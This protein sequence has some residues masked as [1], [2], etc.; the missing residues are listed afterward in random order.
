MYSSEYY[1]MWEEIYC[2]LLDS[3]Q[4]F[5]ESYSTVDALTIIG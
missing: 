3:D 1:D 2:Q 4:V 5:F